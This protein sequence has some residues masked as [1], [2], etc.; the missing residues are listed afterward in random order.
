MTVT[1]VELQK[2]INGLNETI[3]EIKHE[4]LVASNRKRAL[5]SSM[6]ELT[7]AT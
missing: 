4:N 1:N 6:I 5:T 7:S 3:A 2:K